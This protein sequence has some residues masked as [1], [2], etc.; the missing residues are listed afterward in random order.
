MTPYLLDTHVLL[1]VAQ[2]SPMLSERMRG[3][4]GDPRNDLWFSVVSIWEVVIKSGLDR[5]DFLV[6]PAKLRDRA[7]LAGYRELPVRGS[8][9][10]G[11]AEL[12]PLHGDPFDRLLIAQARIENLDLL[13]VDTTVLRY[14]AGIVEA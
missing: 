11:V 7:L 8:H 10:L 4:V 12:P 14:G 3:I 13:T 6:D 1:W 9:V 2:G 5:A